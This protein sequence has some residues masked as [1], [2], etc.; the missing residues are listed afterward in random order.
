MPISKPTISK[1]SM[2]Y[3]SPFHLL[4]YFAFAD[5]NHRAAG[6]PVIELT[7]SKNSMRY[8][9]PFRF[10]RL[11]LEGLNSF[12]MTS[13]VLT[14][15]G[16]LGSS[17]NSEEYVIINLPCV[18]SV[19]NG[20]KRYKV[21]C[22][23]CPSSLAQV[24]IYVNSKPVFQGEKIQ[25]NQISTT[26][27]KTKTDKLA[28]LSHRWPKM[29]HPH[30]LRGLTDREA[31]TDAVYRVLLGLDHND[32][33]IFESAFEGED[34]LL[35]FRGDEIKGLSTIKTM[36]LDHVGPM[37]TTHMLSNVRVDIKEGEK[38]ASLSANGMAQH[39]PPGRGTEEDGPKYTTASEYFVDLVKNEDGHWKIKTWKMDVIWTQGDQSTMQ[40]PG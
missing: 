22:C 8:F 12:Q 10:C 16:V 14:L 34:V 7:I 25:E 39:C 6:V 13:F 2:R 30:T 28:A 11:Q 26:K 21:A 35:I 15:H 31:C 3:F 29:S 38:S 17:S 27:R 18:A 40:R 32:V 33:S 4:A 20:H 37:A 23:I 5:C 9:S 24:H 1:N 19:V 36:F